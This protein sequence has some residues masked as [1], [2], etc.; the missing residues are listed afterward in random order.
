MKRLLWH[1][2]LIVV[3]CA[4]VDRSYADG[5]DT[6]PISDTYTYEISGMTVTLTSSYPINK[7]YIVQWD[8]GDGTVLDAPAIEYTYRDMGEYNAC[9]SILDA[10]SG[11]IITRN[12]QYLKLGVDTDCS[13]AFE[14]VCGCDNET[15]M[16]ACFAE[17]VYGVYDYTI[18][19]CPATVSFSIV[20]Q[21]TFDV[22]DL[23]INLRN[24]SIGSYDTFEWTFGDGVVSKKRNTSHTYQSSGIYEVCLSVSHSLT[25]TK[26]RICNRVEVQASRPTSF[27]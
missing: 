24:R 2:A 27:N 17:N 25:G 6:K 9:L 26:E 22:S 8:M 1:V 16:N 14:P 21:Y 7:G 11:E 13:F 23:S 4:E 20:P 19:A 12:C 3:F 10:I 15:Y 5:F 18:G